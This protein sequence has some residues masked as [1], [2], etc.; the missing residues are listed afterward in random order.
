MSVFLPASKTFPHPEPVEG[1]MVV[2]AVT[3]AAG[4]GTAAD[5]DGRIECPFVTL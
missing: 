4:R 5:R 3:H 2:Q 1:R